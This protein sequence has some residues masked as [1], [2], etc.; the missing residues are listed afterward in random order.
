MKK[1][2]IVFDFD[3]TIADSKEL[4]VKV[5]HDSLVKASF[6]YPRSRIV[7]ALGP[8]LKGTLSNLGKFDKKTLGAL[9]K[10]INDWVISEAE[11]LKV[12]PHVKSSL[13]RL[14][15]SGKFRTILLT[16]SARHFPIAFLKKN[17]MERYFD[18]VMGSEDFKDKESA[19]RGIAKKFNVKLKDMTYVGDKTIDYRLAR[20]VGTKIILPYAC[21]WDKSLISRRKYSKARIASLEEIENKI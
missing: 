15:K 9:S 17:K 4:Y 18:I 11:R 5:I 20:H 14:K 16:N 12:C 1:R 10:E 19:L 21:S 13:A 6:I 7:R 2:I 8:K 3:G